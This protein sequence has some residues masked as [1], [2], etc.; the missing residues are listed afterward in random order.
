[1][2][3]INDYQAAKPV[4][5]ASGKKTVDFADSLIVAKAQFMADQWGLDYGG[6]FTFD[7]AALQMGGIAMD[8]SGK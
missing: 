7:Q 6:T 3:R 1:M 2:G 5:T 4:D 8:C